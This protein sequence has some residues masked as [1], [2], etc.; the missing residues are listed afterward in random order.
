MGNGAARRAWHDCDA[1]ARQAE[2]DGEYEK[3]DGLQQ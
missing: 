1:H 3:D 2:H